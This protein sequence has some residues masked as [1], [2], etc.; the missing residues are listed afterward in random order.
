MYFLNTSVLGREPSAL[1]L[2]LNVAQVLGM[3]EFVPR[4]KTTGGDQKRPGRPDPFAY[5]AFDKRMLNKRK[6][7]Q[8]TKSLKGVFNAS[9]NAIAAVAKAKGGRR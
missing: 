7:H 8:P 5:V 9:K 2:S 6:K 3:E 1:N 4:S